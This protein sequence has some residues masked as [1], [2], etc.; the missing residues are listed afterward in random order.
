MMFDVQI[1][2]IEFNSEE[3]MLRFSGFEKIEGWLEDVNKHYPYIFSLFV[4]NTKKIIMTKISTLLRFFEQFPNHEF[5]LSI[6]NKSKRIFY[7]IS[8]K[9]YNVDIN[10][11]IV[12]VVENS[13]HFSVKY[14]VYKSAVYTEK[15]M[16][17]FQHINKPFFEDVKNLPINVLCI[18]SCFSRSIFKSDSF[19]N[20]SYKQYFS[21]RKTLFHNSFISLLSAPIKYDYLNIDDL[22]TGDAG[23]YVN[24]EFNKDLKKILESYNCQLIVVDNYIDATCPV[25]KFQDNSYLTYNKYFSESIFKRFFSS[26]KVIYPGSKE[27]LHLYKKSV[28][29]FHSLLSVFKIRNIVLVGGR[30]CKYKIDTDTQTTTVWNDKMEWISDTNCAWDYVDQAF[31]REFSSAIYLDKRKTNWKS[32]I[33]TPLIGGASPSHYQ[34][35][36][37]K[38]MFSE[39]LSFICGDDKI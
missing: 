39:L 32:D 13:I 37:Y 7:S 35:G 19:F 31:L 18:S 22:I 2:G 29:K 34:S 16:L 8:D 21:V 9:I 23:K 11:I 36:Y 27:H 28:K 6:C 26:C 24:V 17:E 30:L 10:N 4:D 5:K 15:K 20:P 14:N 12:F 1:Q 33:N 38:E 3:L 25:I